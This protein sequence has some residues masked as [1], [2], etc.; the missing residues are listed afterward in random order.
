M[1]IIKNWPYKHQFMPHQWQP[2][3]SLVYLPLFLPTHGSLIKDLL[4]VL[5]HLHLDNEVLDAS[6]LMCS[7][8]TYSSRRFYYMKII[9]KMAL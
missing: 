9:K 6:K 3:V 2:C 8:F 1:K 5:V 4:A 7:C